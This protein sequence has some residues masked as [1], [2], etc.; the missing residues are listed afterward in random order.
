M[1][2]G[3]TASLERIGQT[4]AMYLDEDFVRLSVITESPDIPKVYAELNK[5]VLFQE[6]RIESQ[7]SNCIFFEIELDLLSRALSS[8]KNAPQ[9]YLKLVKRGQRPCLCLET[10]ASEADI[11]HDIP[12]KIMRATE[13]VAYQPPRKF[14]VS[15]FICA[16]FFHF[17]PSISHTCSIYIYTQRYQCQQ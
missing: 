10:R 7:S 17:F 3:V 2:H 16:V 4:T 5:N 11:V 13:I 14:L 8:G 15:L 6:Y 1:L 9:C 12:V